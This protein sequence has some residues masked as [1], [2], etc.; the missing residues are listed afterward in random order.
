MQK[1]TYVVALAVLGACAGSSGPADLQLPDRGPADLQILFN[2][3]DFGG[4]MINTYA[5]SELRLTARVLDVGGLE[6]TPP[7]AVQFVSRDTSKAVVDA[8]GFVTARGIL[9]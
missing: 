1:L 9:L 8:A 6:M 2:G 3:V 4:Q 5:T 7:T